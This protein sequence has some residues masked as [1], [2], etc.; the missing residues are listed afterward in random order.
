MMKP[1][2]KLKLFPHHLYV[3]QCSCCATHLVT[4]ARG[5]ATLSPPQVPLCQGWAR[6]ALV[7]SALHCKPLAPGNTISRTLWMLL[8]WDAEIFLPNSCRSFWY[9]QNKVFFPR[10]LRGEAFK[11]LCVFMW[12][13]KQKYLLIYIF[14][15]IFICKIKIA[16]T[17]HI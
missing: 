3:A 10:C 4:G 1:Y 6:G 14:R 2:R 5:T 15:A 13:Y 11:T 17:I 7:A 9:V 16:L 8:S 12:I